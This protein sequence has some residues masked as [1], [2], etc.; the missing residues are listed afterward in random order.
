V[1]LN[2]N[3]GRVALPFATNWK[4][5][6]APPVNGVH[7]AA[8]DDWVTEWF[9]PWNW[10]ETVSPTAAPSISDGSKINSLLAPT[11]TRWS[12]AWTEATERRVAAAATE[13]R[14]LT[15]GFCRGVVGLVGVPCSGR[16][17]RTWSGCH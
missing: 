14:M 7:G 2:V 3:W 9:L 10:K 11:F 15:K 17:S 5:E 13:K 8:N 6:L 4:P 16:T 1:M 12:T